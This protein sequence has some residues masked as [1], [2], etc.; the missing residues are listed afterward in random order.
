MVSGCWSLDGWSSV[1]RLGDFGDFGD[2]ATEAAWDSPT[3]DACSFH[4]S[5][6]PQH[7]TLSVKDHIA[8]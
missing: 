7:V 8:G 3:G 2:P 4:A 5:S 1:E 6:S